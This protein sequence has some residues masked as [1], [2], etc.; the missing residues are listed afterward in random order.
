MGLQEMLRVGQFD[1]GIETGGW[2][3]THQVTE[4][5]DRVAWVMISSLAHK[6]F[7]L[8]VAGGLRKGKQNR[9]LTGRE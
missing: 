4:T 8:I 7:S 6:H 9:K 2:R 3:K 5:Q 1:S